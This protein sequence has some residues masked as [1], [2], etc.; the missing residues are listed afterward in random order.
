MIKDAKNGKRY[1]MKTDK[2]LIHSDTLSYSEIVGNLT[3]NWAGKELH[4]L[5]ETD[6]TNIDAKQYA[7]KG[8]PHGT[9][10]VADMQTAGRGRKGKTWQSPAG[11][12]IY[13]TILL[14]PDFS[15]DKVSMLTLVMGLSVAQAVAE[16]PGL[17]PGIKWPNDIV[18][19]QKK[20]C[21]ILTEME[22]QAEDASYV[23]VGVGINVN[24]SSPD[25]FPE[26]IR[27]TATS[28]KIASGA[29]YSRAALI[30]RVLYYF[31][32]NYDT[33][34]SSLDLSGL[35]ED[36]HKYLLNKDAEVKVLD[37]KGPYIGIARGINE[38]GELLVEKENGEVISVYAGEVSVRGL[39]GYV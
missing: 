35:M 4:Y 8:A 16:I 34:V 6:S 32:K 22:V 15:P 9:V 26:E 14:R 5:D 29:S 27:Q 10:I 19:D 37:P 33:F 39:Y 20:I 36:Y 23:V 3:A 25:E 2:F 12:A 21:G 28:L 11:K 38:A 1:F 18:I 13:M 30:G 31:E 7:H 24:N 17:N